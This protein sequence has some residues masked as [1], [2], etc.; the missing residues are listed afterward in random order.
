MFI[1]DLRGRTSTLRVRPGSY[2]FRPEGA[3]IMRSTL[4]TPQAKRC[5]LCNTSFGWLTNK[6]FL[7]TACGKTVCEDC[8]RG[9]V[10]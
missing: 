8:S 9:S 2:D 4:T 3:P 6:K 1:D 10:R 5:A 7:C